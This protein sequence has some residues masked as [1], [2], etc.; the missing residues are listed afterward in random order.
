VKSQYEEIKDQRLKTIDYR[1]TKLRNEQIE[2]DKK[3]LK[4]ENE[5]KYNIQSQHTKQLSNFIVTKYLKVY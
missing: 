1:I 3:I 4:I 5:M 2:I